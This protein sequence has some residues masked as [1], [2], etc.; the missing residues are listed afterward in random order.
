MKIFNAEAY[1]NYE[2]ICEVLKD[3]VLF[4]K[5]YGT[6]RIQQMAENMFPIHLFLLLLC[7]R[8]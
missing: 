1:E 8:T 6:N 5:N 2:K 3:I 4:T 7:P